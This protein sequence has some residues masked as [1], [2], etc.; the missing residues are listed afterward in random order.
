MG[1]IIAFLY[2]WLFVS[3]IKRYA[4]LQPEGMPVMAA[5]YL[6][7]MKCIVGLGLGLFYKTYY[8]SGDTFGFFGDSGHLFS[9]FF[10]EP[11][12]FVK[13]FFD[14]HLGSPDTARNVA[15]MH[16][17]YDSG[18]DDYYNDARTVVKINALLR[19]I[20]FGYYEVHVVFMNCI[21]YLGLLWIY[22]VFF[23]DMTITGWKNIAIL[24]VG[25]ITPSVLM[26]GSGL[27][28]EPLVLFMVGIILRL[29]QLSTENM[30]IRY[31][32][33]FPLIAFLFLIIKMYLFAI[34]LPG[35]IGIFFSKYASNKR[36]INFILLS[37]LIALVAVVVI[38]YYHPNYDLPAL[39]FGK[40]LNT[41]R[42][43]VFMNAGSV[44]HPVP[45]APNWISFLKHI[46]E[47]IWFAFAHPYPNELV[48]WWMFPFSF[49]AVFILMLYGASFY[50][51]R[52]KYVFANSFHVYGIIVALGLLLL[53]GYTNPVLGN[54][55]RYR[56]VSMI[57]LA[58]IG[59]ASLL[60]SL[61]DTS[62]P[63]STISE[64]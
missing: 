38:G 4:G 26:W 20:S 33:Y 14:Y 31:F 57:L 16:L 62:N 19:F 27:L 43:A 36:Q 41:Y 10:N 9:I 59:S 3:C 7:V 22:R 40:Q 60:R 55:V 46:P 28:K 52:C 47:G 44:V 15:G 58:V 29:T 11:K 12:Q 2:A 23:K 30:R 17:W 1:Y 5:V 49:E 8:G 50:I 45:F 32:I 54:I 51:D 37:Y 24:S 48:Q 63:K 13:I 34:I 53:I 56:M 61:S 21:S 18:F 42:F 35:I 64:K 6:F 39:L 25:F